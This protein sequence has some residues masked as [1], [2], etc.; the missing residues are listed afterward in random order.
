MAR[1]FLP[2]FARIPVLSFLLCTAFAHAAAASGTQG[3]RLE[4]R[5]WPEL[6]DAMRLG[7]TTIILPVGGTEQ[8]GPHMALGKHN[9]RVAVFAERIA[10]QLGHALVAPVIAYV[11]EGRI[12][13]PTG[14]M[15]Y[16]GTISVSDSAFSGIVDGAVRS[17]RQNGFRDIVLIGDSGDY[18]PLL[19][20]AAERF[21]REWGRTDVRVHYIG[22]YYEASTTGF[23]Q[24]LRSRG[25][26][27]AE[28]GTHAGLADTSLLLAAAPSLVRTAALGSPEAASV[29]AGVH[30]RPAQASAAL[31][32]AGADLVV[33]RAVAAIRTSMAASRA[34]KH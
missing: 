33:Q 17:F 12:S 2:S 15:R 6:R 32:Q 19:R 23:A 26:A 7:T 28:I 34:V 8:N 1:S 4:D 14:H 20:S 9:A 25:H 11:P 5:T 30:G 24:L 3:L 27:D 29:E 10:S 31:G 21:N 13:P 18:Q 22:A 16:P